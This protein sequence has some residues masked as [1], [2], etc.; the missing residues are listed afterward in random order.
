MNFIDWIHEKKWNHYA[1]KLQKKYPDW[2]D[3]E[4]NFDTIKFIWGV[5]SA[6]DLSGSS[7][8]LY[9]LNDIE[10]DYDR[11]KQLYILSVESIY[12]FEK[13]KP[14]ESKYLDFLLSE[15]TKFMVDNGY[16]IWYEYNFHDANDSCIFKADSIPKL[17][18][19]FRIFVEGYKALY[20]YY[21][22]EDNNDMKLV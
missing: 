5:K 22:T 17:Y 13:G 20:P 12:H 19:N 6:D 15:F 8:N 7:P 10:I 18:T 16:D 3:N 9:T 2:E 11:E 4:Y 21:I 1:K 14:A